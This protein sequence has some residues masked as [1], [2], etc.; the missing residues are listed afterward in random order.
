VPER[1]VEDL[2]EEVSGLRLAGFFARSLRST[3]ELPLIE[4]LASLGVAAGARPAQSASDRGGVVSTVSS[5]T[6]RPP[7]PR[8]DLGWRTSG[9]AADVKVTHVLEGGAAEAAGVA[10]NDVIVAIDTLRID[11]RTL[12]TRTARLTPGDRPL[13]HAFRRDELYTTTIEARAAP[14]D[15]CEIVMPNTARA[16]QRL[17]R[18]LG[19][20]KK[21]GAT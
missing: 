15:T 19:V 18:W 7:K 10:A 13:L 2:A 11:P 17:D 4:A 3:S 14:A 5:A 12:E 20:S 9:N 21:W 8:I 6:K 1:G 16:R